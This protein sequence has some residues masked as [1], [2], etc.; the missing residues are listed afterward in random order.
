MTHDLGHLPAR[1][2]EA[3]LDRLV[4]ALAPEGLLVVEEFEPTWQTAVL[5]APDL[6]EADH[7]FN[8]YHQAF[9]AA[10]AGSGNDPRWGRH[11]HHALRSR[12]LTVD[13]EGTTRT[14]T[15]GSPACLLPHATAAVIRDRLIAAGM[16]GPDIDAFRQLL[17]DPDLIVKSNL[18]LSHI[19]RRAG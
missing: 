6:D 10:L 13:T 7:L 12:G 17:L 18:A 14:W 8:A 2:R 16:P 9:Q 3:T 4:D 19:G 11:A 15:G 1:E 5:S